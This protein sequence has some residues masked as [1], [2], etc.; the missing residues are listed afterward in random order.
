MLEDY[1]GEVMYGLFNEGP[2]VC[3]FC[4]CFIEI[5]KSK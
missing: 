4:F 2:W 3:Q 5:I 1:K